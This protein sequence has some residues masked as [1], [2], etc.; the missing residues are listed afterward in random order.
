MVDEGNGRVDSSADGHGFDSL[1]QVP[2]LDLG[3]CLTVVLNRLQKMVKQLA[4]KLRH[5]IQPET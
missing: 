5:L 1:G 4:E 3:Q 2:R